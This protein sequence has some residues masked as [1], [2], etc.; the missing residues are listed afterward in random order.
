MLYQ[1]FS[2]NI[3]SLGVTYTT[4]ST[5]TFKPA[6]IPQLVQG[7]LLTMDQQSATVEVD[8]SFTVQLAQT[9]RVRMMVVD[10]LGKTCADLTLHI[11]DDAS[12]D[13]SMYIESAPPEAL[14]N[15]LINAQLSAEDA[16]ASKLQAASS[17]FAAGQSAASASGYKNSA[18]D[19][20]GAAAGSAEAAADSATA[21]AQ[22]ATDSATSSVSLAEINAGTLPFITPNIGAATGTS[23]NLTGTL[24]SASLN[25]GSGASE[26][27]FSG[28]NLYVLGLTSY[29]GVY[30][31]GNGTAG[32]EMF[33]VSHPT[34]PNTVA[35]RTAGT[36]ALKVTPGGDVLIGST[37]DRGGFKLQVTGAMQV[38]QSSLG[39]GAGVSVF[40]DANGVNGLVQLGVL[41]EDLG[42]LQ[43][44]D[45][46]A[47][48]NITISPYG[49]NVLIGKTTDNG[50]GQ[51]QVVGNITCATVRCLST[52]YS[53][54]IGYAYTD[55]NETPGLLIGATDNGK[56]VTMGYND[57]GDYGF[58][59][60]VHTGTA[61]KNI[62][63]CGLGGNLLVG[64]VVPS[65][66]E[67]LEVVGGASF[68]G[69][70]NR[71][72]KLGTTAGAVA[73]QNYSGDGA[74]ENTFGFNA[75]SGAYLCGLGAHGA[76]KD[77]TDFMYIGPSAAA[78]Y[79]KLDSSGLAVPG[80]GSFAG[81]LAAFASA[82]GALY[83]YYSSGGVI[84]AYSD[85]IGTK[86]P[87]TLDGSQ[88]VLRPG[89]AAVATVVATGIAVTGS[90]T[91]TKAITAA[92]DTGESGFIRIDS[93]VSV[94]AERN[95]RIGQ[96]SAYG[97][98]DTAISTTQGGSTFTTIT[99]VSSTGLAVTGELSATTGITSSGTIQSVQS[100]SSA[101]YTGLVV[102]NSATTGYVN[103]QM[104]ARAAD[105]LGIGTISY[106]K[107]IWMALVTDDPT[108][109]AMLVNG[110]TVAEVTTTG[111][112][113]T[114][115]ISVSALPTYADN[116]AAAALTAGKFYRTSTG[117]VMVKY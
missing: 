100:S 58:L 8:G 108:P 64:A 82:S 13:L 111:L 17:A 23:L 65:T 27:R 48:R 79:A 43:A 41:S 33:G 86:A 90:V 55:G 12:A 77:T 107:G 14:R 1:V 117:V 57:S 84:G 18:A 32:I 20:A 5:V 102:S 38:L 16:Y 66:G 70:G 2:G 15:Q 92:G 7:S 110:V 71:I 44:S 75:A 115:G 68:T 22:S 89:G 3:A 40:A 94:A 25:I 46:L 45:N 56:R 88:V 29:M 80:A 83:T 36:T 51:L 114:G 37:A 96:S 87:L 67:R 72:V 19:S 10:G 116:T 30:G 93:A 104:R 105:S 9:A 11:T 52:S 60:A 97:A 39:M 69:G 101:Y 26:G 50:L 81:S 63:I 109:I 91:A 54:M 42:Y 74:W 85:N 28:N 49:G 106:A 112:S 31:D 61:W 98:F 95:F 78:P 103:I 47:Y 6:T 35:L 34:A 59:S 62:A 53:A 24:T 73:I 4:G 113:I 76:T 21:A 99:S